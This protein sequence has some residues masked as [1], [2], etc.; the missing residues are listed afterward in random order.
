MRVAGSPLL[1]LL[2]L[3]LPLMLLAGCIEPMGIMLGLS[4][5]AVPVIGR[6]LPDAVYS[7]LTGK[8]CSLVRLDAGKSYC[9]P[10]EAP[11]ARPLVCTRSLGTVDC[12]GNA[13][14]LEAAR[15]GVPLREVA[16]GPRSLTPAQEAHRTR[17]WPGW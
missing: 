7:G 13:E 11:P 3:L 5:A 2:P 4:A 14:V 8:D 1:R 16:D 17:R 9:A 15:L 6:T 10:T 12:W